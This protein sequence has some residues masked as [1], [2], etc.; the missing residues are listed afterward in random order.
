MLALTKRAFKHDL[1]KGSTFVF[2]GSVVANILNYLFHVIT[3]RMLGPEQYAVLAALI[4]LSYVIGFPNSLISTIVTRKIATLA[5]KDDAGGIKGFL[6][7]MTKHVFILSI[8]IV[9]TFFLFQDNIADF[10]KIKDSFLVMLL[11]IGFATALFATVFLSTFQG[12][13][14]FITHSILASLSSFFRL[15]TAAI[16]IGLSFGVGGVIWGFVITSILTLLIA[17]AFL[18]RYWKAKSKTTSMSI[19]SYSSRLWLAISL[20]GT[21]LL[22]NVDVLLVKHFFS[23]YDAGLYAALATLGKIVLFFSGSIATVLL[24]IASRK[25]AQGKSARKDLLLAQGLIVLL[26]TS[27]VG[28]YVVMPR[29]V[30][31]TLYGSEYFAIAPYMWLVG[32]YFVFFNVSSTFANYFISIKK[33]YIL[34]TPLLTAFVQI[35][36]IWLFHSSF[37]QI[38]GIMIGTAVIQA[39]AF[40]VYYLLYEN[41]KP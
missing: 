13:L 15:T 36:G 2:L 7:I 6:I 37:Y 39:I 5:A 18:S 34:A 21:G 10:L 16:A 27:I 4:S 9:T 1:I 8:F 29:F 3:G 23:D 41:K 40:T 30:I 11:G 31:S 26:S 24:P 20:L 22:I 19:H 32:I 25:N 28:V 17:F 12:L 33:K 14:R 38:L 35:G